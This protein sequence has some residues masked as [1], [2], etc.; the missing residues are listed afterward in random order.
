MVKQKYFSAGKGLTSKSLQALLDASY[1]KKGEAP[2]EVNGYMY[3]P[4][5]STNTSKVY[6]DPK[7]NHTV[8]AHRGTKGIMDWANNAVYAVAGR[9]GYKM[10]NRYKDAEKTHKAAEEKYG[11]DNISSIGHSQGALLARMLGDKNKEVIA[12]NPAYNPL[13]SNEHIKE[14]EHI[15]RHPK[16]AVSIGLARNKAVQQI[17]NPTKS[18][19]PLDVHS[20]KQL[21]DQG[22]DYYGKKD[23]GEAS[24]KGIKHFIHF[25]YHESDV[26]SQNKRRRNKF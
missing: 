24:G 9:T 16:D 10:T 26:K 2:K 7:T 18:N 21:N 20:F 23:F 1:K 4:D 11:K 12:Y 13:S 6:V 3:D 19:N 22:D 15:L 5:L 25:H 14:N 17:N 8:V